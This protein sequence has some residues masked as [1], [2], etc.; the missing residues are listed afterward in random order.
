MAHIIAAHLAGTV[1]QTVREHR[2]GRIQQQPWAFDRIA[3]HTD[4]PGL[5]K[6]LVAI[7]VGIQNPGDLARLVMLDL[8]HMATLAHFQIAGRFA[9][10]DI[11]IGGGPFRAPFAALK[12]EP[13]LLAGCARAVLTRLDRHPAGMD[14]F[15]PKRLSSGLEHFEIVVA[16]QAGAVAGAGHAQLFLGQII[17]RRHLIAINRPVEQ[18][19]P[20]DAAIGAQRLPFMRL[21]AQG[22]TR[23]MHGGAA[24]GLDDPGGQAG[25][26]L[27][28]APVAAG[29]ARVKPG[30]LAEAVPFVVQVILRQIAAPGLQRDNA[31]A[32]LRQFIGQH[33]ATGPG[34][35][36][37]DHRV[38][39][40]IKWCCHD[41][42]PY[43]QLMSSKPRSI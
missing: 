4:D 11:G 15:I 28:H 35:D 32:L 33:A 42:A 1:G 37:H 38:V 16:G 21:K 10:G 12:A 22:C 23:P 30:Q 3:R 7:L 14:L 29:G 13:G 31:D 20:V 34:A 8:E 43:I 18:I 17:P 9:I 39:V 25:K 24:H 41:M 26:V 5:L 19:G 6:D 27:G 36:N 2:R 40:Q